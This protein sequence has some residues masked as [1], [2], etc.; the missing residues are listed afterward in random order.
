M[1]WQR[2]SGPLRR[3]MDN[4]SWSRRIAK[5]GMNYWLHPLRV[6]LW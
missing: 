2:Y 3:L 5:R 1:V 4:R 6:L